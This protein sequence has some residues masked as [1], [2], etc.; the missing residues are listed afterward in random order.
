M[1][2]EDIKFF[3][4]DK[5]IRKLHPEVVTII[6]WV[7]YDVNE[8]EVTYDEV[9]VQAEVDANAYKEQRAVEYPPLSEQLDY[10]YHNGVEAWKTNMIQPVKDKYPKPTE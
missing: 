10:I 1:N 9:A 7:A 2:N 8:Q 6:D 4:K 3:L 5:A